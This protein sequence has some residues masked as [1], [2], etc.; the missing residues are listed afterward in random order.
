M[1][2][3]MLPLNYAGLLGVNHVRIQ[4]KTTREAYDLSP[5]TE[6]ETRALRYYGVHFGVPGDGNGKIILAVDTMVKLG[7]DGTASNL[8][9]Y[10]WGGYGRILTT[11]SA[12][13]S[14]KSG[15]MR[16]EFSYIKSSI[17]LLSEN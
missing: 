10:I 13:F 2:Q 9:V 1:S 5:W 7:I 14:D 8:R 6:L 3:D 12:N 17:S 4:Y 16:I 15:K 11:G